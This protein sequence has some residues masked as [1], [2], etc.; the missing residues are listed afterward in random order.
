MDHHWLICG[1]LVG[2]VFF[3]LWQLHIFC[4]I[5]YAK[6]SAENLLSISILLFQRFKLFTFN[7]PDV[8][9][10]KATAKETAENA[11]PSSSNPAFLDN[12][13][14]FD[15]TIL[16]ELKNRL[17]FEKL[18]FKLI[19]GFEDA[20]LTGL[21]NG[22]LFALQGFFL[23]VFHSYFKIKENPVIYLQSVY[24]RDFWEAEFD[25]IFK[26]RVGNVILIVLKM[27]KIADYFK[28]GEAK[29]RNIL[30]KT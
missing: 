23:A 28:G 24:G 6:N 12:L 22:A 18:R 25:C 7:I 8:G 9:E 10:T 2:A 20:A 11:P 29:W 30:F 5:N 17:Y 16:R 27:L 26:I 4:R 15:S 13:T 3:L 14:K 1:V 21:T 19:Y